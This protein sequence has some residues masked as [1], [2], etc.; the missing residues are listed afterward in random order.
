MMV[1]VEVEGVVLNLVSKSPTVILKSQ[2]GKLLPIV[3]GF[4]EA[5][6]ILLAIENSKAQASSAVVSVRTPGVFVTTFPSS[7]AQGTS[8]LSKPTA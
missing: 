7:V 5:Q 6:S 1:K 4:F 8:I 3:I 2:D